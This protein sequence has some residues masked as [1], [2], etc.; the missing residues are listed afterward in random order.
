MRRI[1]ADTLYW[2][3]LAHRKDQWHARAVQVSRQ[4]GAALLVTTDEVLT[5][6]LNHF[7]A[8]GDQT[9]YAPRPRTRCA[10]S[11]PIPP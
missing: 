10:D 9:R 6:F 7:S 8:F 11:S 2:V 4:I 3:A 1:F 5:E